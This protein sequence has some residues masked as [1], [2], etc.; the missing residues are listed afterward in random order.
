MHILAPSEVTLMDVPTLEATLCPH[1]TRLVAYLEN[2]IPSDLRRVIESRDVVQDTFIQA[3]RFSS[4]ANLNDADAVWRW[5]A[6][7]GRNCLKDNV[8]ALRAAKRGGGGRLQQLHAEESGHSSIID[9][10]AELAVDRHTPSKSAVRRE[11]LR[12]LGECIQRLQPDYR[13]AVTFRYIQGL[14]LNETAMKMSRTED[15]ARKL[16][17]RGVRFLREDLRSVSRFL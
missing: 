13:D 6:T 1:V 9:L 12:V 8:R 5:L 14:S 11:F 4:H 2:Q 15:S 3:A 16:C 7:I 10:L 17:V